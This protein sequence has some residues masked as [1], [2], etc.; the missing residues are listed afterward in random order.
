MDRVVDVR[1]E[2]Y[3]RRTFSEIAS[4]LGVDHV[5]AAIRRFSEILSALGLLDPV[6]ENKERDLDLLTQ[7]VNP[8][9]LK[10][11]PVELSRSAIQ[12]LYDS[13]IQ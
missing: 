11:N 12:S 6:S 2:L 4:A 3:L 1:G 13:I 8:V 7:A 9:R 5:E 10:N